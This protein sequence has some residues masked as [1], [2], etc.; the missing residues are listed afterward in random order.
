MGN[1][2][3]RETKQIIYQSKSIDESIVSI[4]FVFVVYKSAVSTIQKNDV[5][6]FNFRQ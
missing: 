3:L 6:C 1:A 2:D 5:G 4:F